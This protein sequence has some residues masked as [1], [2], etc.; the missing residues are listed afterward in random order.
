MSD[1]T[2]GKRRATQSI[3]PLRVFRE[4][5]ERSA[6]PQDS[7]RA[8]LAALVELAKDELEERGRFDIPGLCRL[9][10]VDRAPRRVIFEGRETII[11]RRKAVAARAAKKL[12]ELFARPF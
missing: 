4:L 1:T 9:D 12:R 10:I 2:V 5:S 11:P 3:R 6:V 7:V 8:V